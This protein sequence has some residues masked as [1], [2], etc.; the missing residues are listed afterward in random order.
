M[1]KLLLDVHVSDRRVGG[2]LR[3]LGHDVV[4][5][6]ADEQLKRLDDE[7]LLEWAWARRRI[8]VTGNVRDFVP[9]TVK[10]ARTGKP[11]AGCILFPANVENHHHGTIIA[12][13]KALLLGIAQEDWKDLVRWLP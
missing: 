3:D 7:P 2:P 12:G 5:A 10:W 13:V 9:I 11:H 8:V 1:V 4:A 6:Q